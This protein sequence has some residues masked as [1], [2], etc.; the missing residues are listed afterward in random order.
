MNS[1]QSAPW[2]LIC[3]IL[4]LV[5]FGI[6]AVSAT[7]FPEPIPGRW[8]RALVATGLFFFVASMI[9]FT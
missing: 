3:L 5:L 7:F 2:R 8:Y 4:S 6:A 1:T 9:T